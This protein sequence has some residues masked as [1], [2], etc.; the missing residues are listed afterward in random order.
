MRTLTAL[1][2]LLLA[3]PAYAVPITL[4]YHEDAGCDYMCSAI[5]A[6]NGAK[7]NFSV[8][9][10]SS[11]VAP[12]RFIH[13]NNILGYDLSIGSYHLTMQNNPNFEFTGI[14]PSESGWSGPIYSSHDWSFSTTLSNGDYFGVGSL[15][16]VLAAPDNHIIAG[17]YPNSENTTFTRTQYSF[18]DVVRGQVKITPAGAMM[19]A[20]F[21]PGF[22][23]SLTDAAHLGGFDHFNWV[24]VN[25]KY[26][27]IELSTVVPTCGLGLAPVTTPFIDPVVGGMG[28]RPADSL[29][30]YWDEGPLPFGCPSSA[31][32]GYK[33]S[34]NIESVAD[35]Q[36]HTVY[37]DRRLDFSDEPND[38]FIDW[39]LGNEMDFITNLVGVRSDGSWQPLVTWYWSSDNH[40][41][42]TDSLAQNIDPVVDTT[43]GILGYQVLDDP[44]D[45]PDNVLA[46]YVQNGM[47]VD[48]PEPLTLSMFAAGLVGL[49]IRRRRALR[50]RR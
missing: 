45:V 7:L 39:G 40:S 49:G 6:S 2:I 18:A 16:W 43:G 12:D 21:T 28:A 19:Q 1:A 5:G 17:L 37:P 23:L 46:L 15:G 25:T 30:Y 14:V 26:P 34:D 9:V 20:H 48:A 22:G 41:A 33:L 27:G 10:D 35:V 13:T 38:N 44:L 4:T 47:R 31:N 32:N 3:T 50:P 24:Q 8:T 42:N 11:Q 36:N 29:P